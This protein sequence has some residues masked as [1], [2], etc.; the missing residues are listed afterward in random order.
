MPV[1]WLD[2]VRKRIGELTVNVQVAPALGGAENGGEYID[3]VVAR[4]VGVASTADG[5]YFLRVGDACRPVL[6]DDVLTLL[7]DRPQLPWETM[8]SPGVPRSRAWSH[9]GCGR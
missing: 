1:E 5:R 6:G 4:A 9:I 7:N 3:L 8:R 2:R